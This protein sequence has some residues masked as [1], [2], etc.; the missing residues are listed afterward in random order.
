MWKLVRRKSKIVKGGQKSNHKPLYKVIFTL[1]MILGV[2]P[3]ELVKNM[4][5]KKIQKYAED[6]SSEIKKKRE[7]EVKKVLDKLN[8]K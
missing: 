5:M 8:K 3:K 2:K 6:M 7:K 4:N 1:A